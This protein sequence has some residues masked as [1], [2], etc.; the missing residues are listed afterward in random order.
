[1]ENDVVIKARSSIDVTYMLCRTTNDFIRAH[2]S[3]RKMLKDLKKKKEQLS[4]SDYDYL[5]VYN[6]HIFNTAF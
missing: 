5:Y 3:N 1:M 4:D 6:K 2:D